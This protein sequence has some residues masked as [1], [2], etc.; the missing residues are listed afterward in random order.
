MHQY[1]NQTTSD[2]VS[3]VF[4]LPDDLWSRLNPIARHRMGSSIVVVVDGS[5][6]LN[7]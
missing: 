5:S 7:L 2:G 4:G 6:S 3:P 1:S